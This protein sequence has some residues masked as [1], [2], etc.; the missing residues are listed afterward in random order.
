M[1]DRLWGIA[2]TTLERVVVGNKGGARLSILI[3]HGVSEEPEALGHCDVD[4][5]HFDAQVE[6][7]ARNY[8][9]L[10]L[11]EAV[12]R[13][14]ADTLPR[15]SLVITFDDGYA[16]NHAVALPVLERHGVPATFFVAS[17]YLDGGWMF[18]DVVIDAIRRC[19]ASEVDLTGLGLRVFGLGDV[20]DRRHAIQ[21][22]VSELKYL[23]TGVREERA[24]EVRQACGVDVSDS[25]MMSSEQ[26]HD[27]SVR[28][29]EVGGH[30]VTHPILNSVEDVKASVE[31]RSGKAQLEAIVGA[32]LTV[33][34]YPNG[35]PNVDYS[36]R[37]VGMVREA[38]FAAAVSMARGCAVKMNDNLQLPRF[39][40][41][42]GVPGKFLC[43]L[44][45]SRAA[46]PGGATA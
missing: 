19:Q 36:A 18:N 5:A 33:F 43:R 30:T 7:L 11:S 14:R 16:N 44:A 32:E 26:V 13:L 24:D 42:D 8:C 4:R 29:M 12:S 28:G 23:P 1:L 41:W 38:G 21:E 3:Y 2:G 15:N 37:H 22:V 40:P 34:S 45:W 20:S 6:V 27:L 17:G 25:L 46:D 10:R 9:V 39:T 35:K 31:I